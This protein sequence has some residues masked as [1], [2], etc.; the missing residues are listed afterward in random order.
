VIHTWATLGEVAEFIRG[1]TYKPEDVS[2]AGDPNAL[3]CMRTKNIQADLEIDDLVYIPASGINGLKILKEGDV[4]ISSANSWNLVGKC[5]WIPSLTFRSTFGGFTTVLRAGQSRL[6]PRYLYRWFSTSPVQELARSFGQQTTNISNLNLGRCLELKIPLPPL[7]EQRRIAVILDKADALRRKRKRALTLLDSLTHSIFLE[8]F[9]D[10]QNMSTKW[11]RRSLRELGQ[12]I[13][14]KTPPTENKE[15][16]IGE[17]PFIT[18]GDLESGRAASRF[19]SSSGSSFTKV[20]TPGSALVCCIGATIG[21]MDMAA[22]KSAFNQQ[23][24]A[25]EWSKH[26]VPKFGIAALKFCKKEIVRRA[27]STTLPIL[28]KSEFEKL[29]IIAPPTNLQEQFARRCISLDLIR[30]SADE[31]VLD[32]LFS[33]LQSRAFSGQL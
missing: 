4:L 20:V 25:V 12:V 15:Y 30:A 31:S 26:I 9:G 21:K 32:K 27:I 33:S 2:H 19:L 5:C 23:I 16:F 24:N 8:M 3:P 18:P 10:P 1:V 7:D 11:D 29:E 17:I 22:Q 28:K 6:Y 14:G 13:T